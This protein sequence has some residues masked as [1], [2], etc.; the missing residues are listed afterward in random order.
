MT[1]SA[2][3]HKKVGSEVSLHVKN[4]EKMYAKFK[5][6]PSNLAKQRLIQSTSSGL[7]SPNDTGSG[8]KLLL[9]GAVS[10]KENLK[11]PPKAPLITSFQGQNHIVKSNPQILSPKKPV[12]NIIA[13]ASKQEQSIGRKTLHHVNGKIVISKS[14]VQILSERKSGGAASALQ[15]RHPSPNMT[16]SF[17]TSHKNVNTDEPQIKEI[18]KA[19]EVVNFSMDKVRI[20][21]PVP[22]KNTQ[23]NKAIDNQNSFIK[24]KLFTPLYNL[25]LLSPS[26]SKDKAEPKTTRAIA[27]KVEAKINNIKTPTGKPKEINFNSKRD[28]KNE[29][30]SILSLS[31]A[32]IQKAPTG[33]QIPSSQCKCYYHICNVVSNYKDLMQKVKKSSASS[34]YSSAQISK[35]EETHNL[36][37]IAEKNNTRTKKKDKIE[38]A[39]DALILWI[40]DCIIKF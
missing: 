19:K 24:G 13:H 23:I 27:Q 5:P 4:I 25:R 9:S 28:K 2:T 8:N 1:I 16:T 21:T 36:L 37:K 29:G 22:P 20:K 18:P 17:P 3:T 34:Q 7:I 14:P 12:D 11:K 10:P 31:S 39:K 32:Y 6:T 38:K 35:I 40:I 33:R 30:K 15:L 26:G